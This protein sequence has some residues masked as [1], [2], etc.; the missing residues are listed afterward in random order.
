[1]AWQEHRETLER[2]ARWGWWEYLDWPGTRGSP[3]SVVQQALQEVKA[4]VA[5]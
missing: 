3:G 4:K 1:M 5:L 2:E